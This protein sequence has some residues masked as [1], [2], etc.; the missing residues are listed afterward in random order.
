I[1]QL[2]TLIAIIPLIGTIL[3]LSAKTQ[4]SLV[5]ENQHGIPGFYLGAIDTADFNNDGKIDIVITGSW[6]SAHTPDMSNLTCTGEVR[7]YKN[8]STPGG[9]I[10]FTLQKKL[11]NVIVCGGALVKTGDFN[12]DNRPDF[13]FQINNGDNTQSATA[14][15]MNNGNWNFTREVLPGSF[16]TN[17]NSLGM[18]AIDVDLDGPDDLVF[19][20]DAYGNAPG[21]WYRW[22]TQKKEWTTRQ[23]DFSH[24]I[25]YGGALAAGDLDGDGYPEIAVGGNSD[26]PFGSHDCSSNLMYGQVHRNL[27]ANS[28]GFGK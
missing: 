23:S 18:E 7:L 9:Q 5:R 6:T 27:G 12:G 21:L 17:S 2:T 25:E 14:S 20:S 19:I 8:I 4:I 22:D 16:H 13:A 1:K 3:A 10:K 15:Y 24:N 26:I 28:K 11:Q